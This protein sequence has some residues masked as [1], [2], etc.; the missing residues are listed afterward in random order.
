LASPIPENFGQAWFRSRGIVA[1]QRLFL[2]QEKALQQDK[3]Q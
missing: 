1:N 2:P 3:N